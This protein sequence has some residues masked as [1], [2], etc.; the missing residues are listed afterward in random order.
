V[1]FNQSLQHKARRGE[2][3]NDFGNEV[4]DALLSPFDLINAYP[5]ME[6]ERPDGNYEYYREIQP[7]QKKFHE[8]ISLNGS[9]AKF[10]LLNGG[11]GSG[12]SISCIAGVVA[13]CRSEPGVKWLVT[14]AYDWY[15]GDII[16]PKFWECFPNGQDDSSIL[17]YTQEPLRVVFTNNSEVRFKCFDQ[18]DK[19]RGFDCHRILIEE[20]GELCDGNN[21]KAAQLYRNFLMRLR[22][23]KPAYPLRVIM[24][25][26]P[27]GHNWV[28]KIFIQGNPDGDEGRI[29]DLGI[30]PVTGDRMFYREFE[31]VAKNGDIYY[32]IS[33]PTYSNI[34]ASEEYVSSMIGIFSDE[35]RA[36]MI[37]GSF[38]PIQSVV[39]GPPIYSESSHVI[40]LTEFLA[41]WEITEIPKHWPVVVGIDV[42]GNRSP[43]AIEFYVQT[44]EGHWVCFDEIYQ[45]ALQ[46]DDVC[47][48]IL[49][50]S[51]GFD[52][53]QY[54]VDPKSGPMHQ[55]PSQTTVI[56]EFQARGIYCR[57]P[58]GYTK[59]GGI[60]RVCSMLSANHHQQNS[61]M[62]DYEVDPPP[63]LQWSPSMPYFE[64]GQP[65]LFYL[66]ADPERRN[67]KNPFGHRCPAN[68]KEKTVYRYDNKKQMQ[69]K[70]HEEGLSPVLSEKVMDRDD[71]AQ[72]AEMFFAL[73]IQ[74]DPQDTARSRSRRNKPVEP[75]IPII[76]Y[77]GTGRRRRTA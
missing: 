2:R 30:S 70:E 64:K 47:N 33:V 56:E 27:G 3:L 4:L 75:I 71:H 18:P 53:I 19:V 34:Y 37:D 69:P 51:S 76:S 16:L 54:F 59:H 73:G 74:V 15:F 23:A 6:R 17:K 38:A 7:H 14:T 66:S 57:S 32:C 50:M 1:A 12:K 43:W 58:K 45:A 49:D 25:Q 26:N 52:N 72:T 29:H 48:M 41:Y 67:S 20:A 40:G 22:T 10:V 77:G 11:V 5:Q 62:V 60:M 65:N 36:R 46:W 21:E 61:Y 44:P 35:L 9:R 28:W 42:G 39:Y 68:L 8:G 24:N 13:S 31:K 63:G 55:G